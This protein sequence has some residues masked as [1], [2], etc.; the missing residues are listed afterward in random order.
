[1]SELMTQQYG[2]TNYCARVAKMGFS[3]RGTNYNCFASLDY[4]LQMREMLTELDQLYNR[5]RPRFQ[6]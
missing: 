6:R 5:F 4:V 3:L 2:G 1:M